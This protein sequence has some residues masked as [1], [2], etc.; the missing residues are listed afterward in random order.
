MSDARKQ[1]EPL[2]PTAFEPRSD[3]NVVVNQ[4]M[5]PTSALL[6]MAGLFI[7]YILFFLLT[8]RSVSITVES[9]TAPIIGLSGLLL[10]FG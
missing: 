4:R 8:A 1:T 10:P 7:A 6:L 5:T 9:E 2:S 3:A